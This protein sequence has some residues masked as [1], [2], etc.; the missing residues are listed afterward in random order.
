MGLLRDCVQISVKFLVGQKF[1]L[2][3]RKIQSSNLEPSNSKVISLHLQLFF[4]D[5]IDTQ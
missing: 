5:V 1:W 2:D 3:S 4:I